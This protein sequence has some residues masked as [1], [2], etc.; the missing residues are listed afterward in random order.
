LHKKRD[1]VCGNEVIAVKETESKQT[2]KGWGIKGV[3]S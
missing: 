2:E 3:E 1:L